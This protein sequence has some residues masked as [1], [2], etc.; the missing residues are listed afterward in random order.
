MLLLC[1]FFD[2]TS[3]S[4]TSGVPPGSVTWRVLTQ[5]MFSNLLK[6]A[7]KSQNKQKSTLATN[8]K[9]KITIS[10]NLAELSSTKFI[11]KSINFT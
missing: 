5:I 7:R 8:N 6:M 9:F 2:G 4:S 1:V 3:P 10:T 11:L